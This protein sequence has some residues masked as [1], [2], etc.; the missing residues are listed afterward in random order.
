MREVNQAGRDLIM[1]FEGFRPDA[2]LC[3]SGKWTIGF[4][5]TRGVHDGM[6]I[7]RAEAEEFLAEDIEDAAS[8]VERFITVPLGDNQFAALVSFT[9]NMGA[10]ALLQSTLR[11]KLN[12]GDH[13]A[14]PAQLRRWTWATHPITREKVE[15]PGLVRRREAEAKLW[16]LADS[17]TAT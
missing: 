8:A 12:A 13:A 4:G 9:F 15:L 11:R 6:E 17:P 16:N 1:E 10:L 2:Y 14:V 7:T 3:P 5:H